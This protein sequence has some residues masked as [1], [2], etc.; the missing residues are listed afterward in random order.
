MARPEHQ[1]DRVVTGGRGET[2]APGQAN[3]NP[4]E[5][6]CPN[7][8]ENCCT[9]FGALWISAVSY[10]ALL[11]VHCRKMCRIC[12]VDVICFSHGAEVDGPFVSKP[13][14]TVSFQL[15]CLTSRKKHL[16]C[17]FFFT[18]ID[19]LSSL[20]KVTGAEFSTIGFVSIVFYITF[21]CSNITLCWFLYL[22]SS[23]TLFI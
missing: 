10:R 20:L 16:K 1:K 19:F 21:Y 17:S 5:N 7:Y 22:S 11:E 12:C 8:R 15:I 13:L 2:V 3:A 4:V 23:L 6:H 14:R 9:V 18:R